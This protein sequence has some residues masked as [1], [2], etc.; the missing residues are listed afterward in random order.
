MV[1]G[2][3]KATNI[4]LILAVF[5][6]IWNIWGYPLTGIHN[7]TTY[8]N[9][10][11]ILFWVYSLRDEIPDTYVRRLMS[12]G[13]Y[14]LTLLFILRYIKYNL[15]RIHTFP[16]RLMWYGY[17]IPLL[18]TPLL[19][20]MLSLSIGNRDRLKHKK[21]FLLL[22]IICALLVVLVLTNDLHSLVMK[23][24]YENDEEYS[25][26]GPLY[27]LIIG[28]YVVLMLSSFVIM[29]RK[30]RLSSYRKY[31]KIPFVIELL[32]GILWFWYYIICNGSSP[33]LGGYSLYNIQEIYVLLFIGFWEALIVIGLIPS[34]SLARDRAWINEGILDAVGKELS[35]IK[36]LLE[37]IDRSDEGIFKKSLA[38]ICL[39]GVY[40]KRR[41]NLE[42][43][44]SDAG[45]CSTS[46]LTLSIREALDYFAF[47]NISA[48]FEESGEGV[49]VPTILIT[50]AY[51]LLKEI[52]Y[53]AE[54]ALYAKLITG[55][56]SETVSFR[57]TIES[58]MHFKKDEANTPG[59]IS[60]SLIDTELLEALDAQLLLHEE[61]DTWTCD[62][63]ATYPVYGK[64]DHP[65]AIISPR[66]E[67]S[68]FLITH[69]LSLD[70]EALEAK[71]RIH[72]NLGRCLI[73]AKSYLLDQKLT[74]ADAIISEWNRFIAEM[75]EGNV[76]N[77]FAND[78][79]DIF[80]LID[81][82]KVMGLDIVITGVIPEDESFKSILKDALKCQMTNVIKHAEGKKLIVR[83]SS[84]D[85]SHS[86]SL[87]N[88]GKP[89]VKEI[90]EG[91]GLKN[92]RQ[93]VIALGGNME[94]KWKDGFEL[95][96]NVPSKKA[97][98]DLN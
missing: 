66:T 77:S 85:D 7:V 32:G 29:Y 81:R 21:L 90:A 88:D 35:E 64:K 76:D 55:N 53:R 51:D 69:Y 39:L 20:F 31:W 48:G 47:S 84:G 42:F 67:H 10:V 91:G 59:S 50:C 19:S 71:S 45:T 15:V 75:A 8:S 1:K 17:Y 86:I 40:I 4:L 26:M 25:R 72:D 73:M 11:L 63:S 9:T 92:L 52:A 98:G 97:E 83:I 46:E 3:L 61:D 28:W 87:T 5:G 78:D 89:P 82:A 80:Y 58:D 49:E 34:V 79:T 68:L 60:S 12:L 27:F 18:I 62:L 36:N 95:L 33:H 23:I 56:T 6:A 38:R 2:R 57:L 37:T 14:L 41:A 16:H 96:I 22:Q 43:I 44:S 74:S 13:G 70:K 94:I 93:H 54:S 30:C 24:W 65:G